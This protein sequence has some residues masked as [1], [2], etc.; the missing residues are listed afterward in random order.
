LDFTLVLETQARYTLHFSTTLKKRRYL[1]KPQ[2]QALRC[3]RHSKQ[4]N[5]PFKKDGVLEV[6]LDEPGI[7]RLEKYMS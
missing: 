2:K 1:Q 7:K 4:K 6:A 3:G 5:L